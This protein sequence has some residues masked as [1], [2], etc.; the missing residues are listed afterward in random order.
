VLLVGT[1]TVGDA[2]GVDRDD[3]S[4]LGS[5]VFA[6][7]VIRDEDPSLGRNAE[8][9][10]LESGATFVEVGTAKFGAGFSRHGFLGNEKPGPGVPAPGPIPKAPRGPVFSIYAYDGKDNKDT[11]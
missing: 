11:G 5:D 10:L 8:A 2:P 1:G 4:V 9:E 6:V 3:V 7:G